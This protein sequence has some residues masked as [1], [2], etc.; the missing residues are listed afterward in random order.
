MGEMIHEPGSAVVVIFRF[1][2]TMAKNIPLQKSC[3]YYCLGARG[4]CA[5]LGGWTD[6]L[7]ICTSAAAKK[8]L[9]ETYKVADS[10]PKENQQ[11]S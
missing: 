4:E 6:G 3:R 11:A 7:R 9:L 2:C 1:L 10:T 8:G 5:Q